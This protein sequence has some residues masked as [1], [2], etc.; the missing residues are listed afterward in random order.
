M[1][2]N[3]N[4]NT[5]KKGATDWHIP[6][7]DN[8]A[9]IDTDMEVRD[10][11]AAL[12]QYVP[13]DGAK[14]VATDTLNVFF[15]DG[16]SWTKAYRAGGTG[17][18]DINDLAR[19]MLVYVSAGTGR[20][21]IDP[22]GSATPIQDAMDAISE[23]NSTGGG[24]IYL[25]AG[26][27]REA[28]PIRPAQR[29]DITG[30][31][32]YGRTETESQIRITGDGNH[33]FMFDM[34][35]GQMQSTY[36]SF[37]VNMDRDG[38]DAEG[39]AAIYYSGTGGE[40][41]LI[42]WRD[43]HLRLGVGPA[44]YAENTSAPFEITHDQIRIEQWDAGD[45]NAVIE[46]LSGGA[47]VKWGVMAFYP[48]TEVSGKH[49]HIFG[50]IEGNHVIDIMNIGGSPLK[51]IDSFSARIVCQMI[52]WEPHPD[53]REGA[54]P[55]ALCTLG[56]EG[57]VINYLQMYGSTSTAP[58]AYELVQD[59]SDRL[60]NLQLAVPS[61]EPRTDPASFTTGTVVD[62]RH[63]TSGPIVYRGYSSDVTNNAGT[64]LSH[65]VACLGDLTT[66][67]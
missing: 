36:Q 30:I 12:S 35:Y 18:S 20:Q 24:H 16:T 4:Y 8:F 48:D 17:G 47:P 58:H 7:N 67:S 13:K 22:T 29:T 57:S 50:A 39:T 3:H 49:S 63:D 6:L 28:G 42:T 9:S 5:P 2:D 61:L 10:R 56:A 19:G 53:H 31:G 1:T 41:H 40:P 60:G 54:A 15:G 52:N 21:V 55:S 14:F 45:Y 59:N 27:I 51:A 34:A 37:G 66:V 32:G 11:E 26:T 23:N 46:W 65:P 33:A 64:T 44:I 38:R 62:V 43:I 25:P